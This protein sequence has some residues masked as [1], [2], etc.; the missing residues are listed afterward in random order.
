[1]KIDKTLDFFNDKSLFP[2][3]VEKA[4]EMLR[5]NGLPRFDKSEVYK[6]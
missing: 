1:M 4:N 3:K 5:K 2:D 6:K